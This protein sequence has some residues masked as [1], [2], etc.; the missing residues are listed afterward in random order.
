M[1]SDDQSIVKTI[2]VMAHSLGL[3]VIAEGVETQAQQQL[4]FTQGCTQYQG[5]LYSK[6]VPIEQ[7]EVLLRQLDNHS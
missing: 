5:Y 4:L 7:F 3:Q 6:P 2:I 1:D